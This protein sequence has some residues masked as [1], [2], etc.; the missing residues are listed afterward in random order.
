MNIDVRLQEVLELCNEKIIG[1]DCVPE[2]FDRAS[3]FLGLL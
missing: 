2:S 1:A 3:L